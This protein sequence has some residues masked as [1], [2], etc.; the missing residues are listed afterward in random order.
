MPFYPWI[1]GQP[2]NYGIN[3]GNSQDC[4]TQMVNNGLN[5]RECTTALNPVCQVKLSTDFQLTGLVTNEVL[6]IYYTLGEVESLN[7]SVHKFKE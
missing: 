3:Y 5:D 4:V 7:S 6:D 1:P 2:N